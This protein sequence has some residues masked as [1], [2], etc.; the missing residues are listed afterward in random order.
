M[1]RYRL[2]FTFFFRQLSQ[3]GNTE[4]KRA[5]RDM[6]L[7]INIFDQWLEDYNCA[8]LADKQD[9]HSFERSKRMNRVNPKYI[10]RND[11]AKMQLKRINLVI[12]AL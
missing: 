3:I 1:V 11:F 9:I 5:I 8:L 10:L 12:I 4:I 2:Y 7:D 6:A